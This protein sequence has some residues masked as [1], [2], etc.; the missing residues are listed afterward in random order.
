MRIHPEEQWPVDLLKVAVITN[1]LS[2]GQDV[3]L[4]ECH[5]HRRSAMTRRTEGNP[6]SGIAQI[7]PQLVIGCD[8]LR[9]VNKNGWISRFPGSRI[10]CHAAPRRYP[11]RE[12]HLIEVRAES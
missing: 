11:S 10:N 1:C 12:L 4:V 2:D 7:R 3:P 9:D 5:V 8:Q 6:L